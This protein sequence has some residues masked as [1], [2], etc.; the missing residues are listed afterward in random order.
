LSRRV[1][2]LLQLKFNRF[3][4][5]GKD[6]KAH[7][8]VFWDKLCNPKREGGLGIKN[9]EVWNNASILQHIWALFTKAGS[10]WVA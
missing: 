10:L 8:K 5:G 4:W 3:L 7:A 2:F 6:T 1:I 9:L